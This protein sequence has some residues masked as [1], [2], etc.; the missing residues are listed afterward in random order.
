MAHVAK[1]CWAGI[2]DYGKGMLSAQLYVESL[3]K[4]FP[5]FFYSIKPVTENEVIEATTGTIP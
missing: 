4:Y 3:R 1:E 5:D 2:R